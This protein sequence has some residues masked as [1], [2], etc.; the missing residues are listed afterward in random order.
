MDW[1]PLF[2]RLKQRHV[3]V[4]GGGGI[5][6]RKISWL[7]KAGANVTVVAPELCA[8]LQTLATAQKL[9]HRADYFAPEM[10]DD[11]ELIIAATDNDQVNAAVAAAAKTRNIWINVVDTP[12]LC[13]FVFPSIVDRS[14]LV[15]AISSSGQAPVLARRLRSELETRLP[16]NYGAVANLAGQWRDK[17]KRQLPSMASRLRFW[18]QFFDGPVAEHIL[19]GDTKA[20]ETWVHDMLQTDEIRHPQGE[21]YLVGGGPGNPDLLTFRAFKLMQQC[22]VVLY[23]RLVSDDVMNL[24]RRDAERIFVGKTADQHPVP[25]DQINQ[26][27][28]EHAR[29]GK[30]VLR[31][32]GGDPFIFGRGGEEIDTLAAAGVN[33]QV[34]PGITAATGCAAYAG[35]PLTHRDHAQSVQFVTGHLQ[36]DTLNLNWAG[37]AQPR[38]TLVFYMSVK[39]LPTICENLIKAGLPTE[40]P[41]AIVERGTTAKQRV[42]TGTL[43]TIAN[44]ARK[45]NIQPP[46]LTIV[47]D[48]VNCR[49]QLQWFQ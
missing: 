6:E 39:T 7:I 4:I 5:A 10:L 2:I 29:A 44:T 33:F 36:Q 26:L 21:V 22:D 42:I 15:I 31:L 20:A 27:L 12:D 32:K 11:A 17:V 49:D 40:H 46:S 37:L 34:V 38:Q 9:Q 14:P 48:V 23:D 28:V 47:G 16:A 43:A 35:I 24:V 13:D 30:R 18:E 45:A 19:S 25:Q 8:P 3:V 41:V 1:F